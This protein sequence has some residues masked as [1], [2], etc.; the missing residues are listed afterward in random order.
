MNIFPVNLLPKIKMGGF[1]FV[2][3]LNDEL[4]KNSGQ[5]IKTSIYSISISAILY[6]IQIAALLIFFLIIWLLSMIICKRWKA[7]KALRSKF[8]SFITLSFSFWYCIEMF[9]KLLLALSIEAIYIIKNSES[10]ELAETKYKVAFGI[11]V[12]IFSIFTIL[13]FLIIFKGIWDLKKTLKTWV[14]T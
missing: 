11:S 6:L 5:S 2:P 12:L 4:Y 3:V 8:L 9:L 1:E 13:L 7:G 10:R 14:V